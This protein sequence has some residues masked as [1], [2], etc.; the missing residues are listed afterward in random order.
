ML[1]VV[2]EHSTVLGGSVHQHID[3]RQEEAR[4]E[5]HL[6]L[7]GAS[8]WGLPSSLSQLA[9]R[10]SHRVCVAVLELL[11]A[12]IGLQPSITSEVTG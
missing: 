7:M 12:L 8:A 4:K 6:Q 11:G 2:C 9:V 10:S 5:Q 1:C 3:C